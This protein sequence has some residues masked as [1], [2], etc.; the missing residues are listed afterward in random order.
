MQITM[1]RPFATSIDSRVQ[2][3]EVQTR[4]RIVD[5]PDAKDAAIER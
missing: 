2:R 1:A 4:A 3:H 5:Y